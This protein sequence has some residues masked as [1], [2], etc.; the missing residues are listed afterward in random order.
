M[1]RVLQFLES[2][3]QGLARDLALVAA[4]L[5]LRETVHPGF[6]VGPQLAGVTIQRRKEHPLAA[7]SFV[8]LWVLLQKFEDHRFVVHTGFLRD[9]WGCWRDA[10]A[11][12][13]SRAGIQAKAVGMS[14][15]F[16]IQSKSWP[17]TMRQDPRPGAPFPAVPRRYGV[18]AYFQTLSHSSLP[19]D[20]APFSVLKEACAPRSA[21]REPTPDLYLWS[22]CALRPL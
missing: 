13:P 8:Y 14:A 2:D 21:G 19:I 16:R 5:R 20:K 11:C 9:K 7:E 10:Q 6:V 3:L 12:R 22:A 17:L 4:R 18:I 1:Q 15:A